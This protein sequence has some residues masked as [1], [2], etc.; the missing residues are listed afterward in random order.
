MACIALF[1]I[2]PPSSARAA[3]LP[4][5]DRFHNMRQVAPRVWHPFAFK[6]YKMRPPSPKIRGEDLTNLQELGMNLS[7]SQCKTTLMLTIPRSN[8]VVYK[9]FPSAILIVDIRSRG[10]RYD[11]ER[12][13]RAIRKALHT[14]D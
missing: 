11:P 2:R 4:S 10:T 5:A 14:A 3:F 7:R 13:E 6:H 1:K 8:Q 9:G 12:G